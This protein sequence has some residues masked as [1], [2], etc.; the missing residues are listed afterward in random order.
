M[1]LCNI[2]IDNLFVSNV[3]VRK[4]LTSEEDETGIYDLANDINANGL[5]NPITVRL[6]GEKYEII[7]GQR[8][9]L[10][11][12]Q[13]NK[14]HIPCNVLNIDTQKAE[15]ISLVE[16]VQRNQMTTCDKVRSYSKLYDV[17]NKD[18]D[19]VISAIHISKQTI[20]KYL[21]L[22]D[23]PEEVLNLLD[24][25]SENKISI[26]VAIEL[27]KLLPNEINTLEVLNKITTLT[28]AQK[29]DAIKQFK[30]HGNNDIN[31]LDD[32]KDNVVICSNNISLAPSFPY[33]IDNVSNKYIRIPD[34]MFDE[35]I[36]LIKIKTNG[37]LCYC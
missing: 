18:I 14:T 7:A 25:N 32:I 24:T 22:R 23:L 15:E 35:I 6:N 8:R 33:V 1:E 4:T 5:I 10:A 34:N 17:Y 16:N 28:N 37:N 9:F 26:D 3:N 30:Q 13:L 31:I 21:K 36:N 20:Q 29:I 11:M 12:K 19:K 2:E 27:T